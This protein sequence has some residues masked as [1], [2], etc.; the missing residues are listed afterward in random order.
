MEN[1]KYIFD[2][3]EE[4]KDISEGGGKVNVNVLNNFFKIKANAF[5]ADNII[6]FSF[7]RIL[8][9]NINDLKLLSFLIV[10]PRKSINLNMYEIAYV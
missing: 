5:N 8:F 2:Y 1:S 6:T 3:F 9:D 4:K 10:I 7:M